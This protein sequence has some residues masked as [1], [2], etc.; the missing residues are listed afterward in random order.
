MPDDCLEVFRLHPARIAQ[1]YLVVETDPRDDSIA[2]QKAEDVLRVRTARVSDVE[3]KVLISNKTRKL[4][5]RCGLIVVGAF[6]HDL[7]TSSFRETD[8]AQIS[9]FDCGREFGL[10]VDDERADVLECLG[11]TKSGW[12]M[13]DTQDNELLSDIPVPS[14]ASDRVPRP[15]PCDRLGRAARAVPGARLRRAR[16]DLSFGPRRPARTRGDGLAFAS[17]VYLYTACCVVANEFY[18]SGM[19]VVA[20]QVGHAVDRGWVALRLAHFVAASALSLLVGVERPGPGG[21]AGRR[22]RVALRAVGCAALAALMLRGIAEHYRY[23][24]PLP[25]LQQVTI[26]LCAL[27]LVGEALERV[28]SRL[29]GEASRA[30]P[31]GEAG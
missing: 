26:C 3:T 11:A 29:D 31:E 12:R 24:G 2:V 13:R 28:G 5:D 14:N 4:R 25:R 23:Y 19:A 16:R 17:G 18:A 22:G 6:V 10:L 21:K 15:G 27:C 8:E 30:A 9:V 1:V 20:G 7:R